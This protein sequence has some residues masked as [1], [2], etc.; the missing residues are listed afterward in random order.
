MKDGEQSK[1]AFLKTLNS[2]FSITDNVILVFVALGIVY[3]AVQLLFDAIYDAIVLWTQH[4]IPH[5]LSEMMFVLIMMELFRQVWKQINKEAFS[6]N[7]FLYIGFIASI[8]GLLLTQMAISMD[9][10][11][12]TQGTIQ[13]SVHAGIL[14]LLVVCHLLYNKNYQKN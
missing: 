1:S 5:L 8:R 4:T 14:L 3:L 6:L 10:V 13:I 7:P 12:W 2:I 9:D 11:E